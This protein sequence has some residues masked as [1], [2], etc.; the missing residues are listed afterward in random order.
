MDPTASIPA[1]VVV[2]PALDTLTWIK[3]TVQLQ[4]TALNSTGLQL[5]AAISWSSSAPDVAPVS[6]SGLVTAASNGIAS[7]TARAGSASASTTVFVRQVASAFTKESGD[8]QSGT[9]GEPLSASLVVRAEDQGGTPVQGAQLEWSVL[10]GDGALESSDATTGGDG[11]A[12][13]SWRLGLVAGDQTVEARVDGGVNVVF[14]AVS[15]LP[16]ADRL[17]IS[18]ESVTLGLVGDT[19]RFTAEAF[20]GEMVLDGAPMTFVSGDLAVASVDNTG[21]ATAVGEGTATVT[22]QSG[23]ATASATVTVDFSTGPAPTIGSIQPTVL[24]EGETATIT[25]SG[26][27]SSVQ[28]NEVLIDGASATITSASATELQVDV[29]YFDCYPSRSVTVLVRRDGQEDSQAAS[30]TP[31]SVGSLNVGDG[32]YTTDAARCLHLEG[33]GVG[34]E[35]LIGVLSVSEAPSSLTP[36]RLFSRS[37]SVLASAQ[38]PGT[39][40]SP[41]E[42]R[43]IP[44]RFSA[45]AATPQRAATSPVDV[46]PAAADAWREHWRAEAKLR[47][48][49]EE[50]IRSLGGAEALGTLMRESPPRRA[51]GEPQRAVPCVDRDTVT[52]VATFVGSGTIF[53]EDVDNPGPAFL[54]SELQSLDALY[55]DNIAATLS[56]YIGGDQDVDENGRMVVLMTR[57]V[58]EQENLLGYVW[59]GDQITAAYCPGSNEAEIFYGVVPDPDGQVG[60]A[61]TKEDVLDLY[62][63]LIAHEV[64]HIIQ[65]SQRIWS[66]AGAKARWEL[67]GGATFAEQLV[68]NRI[69]GHGSRQDLQYSEWSAGGGWYYD[70]VADLA[71]YFGYQ[72]ST[73]RVSGA[74]EQC[75][76]IGNAS[77]GNDGPCPSSRLVY[78]VPATLLRYV[79]DHWGL[80]FPGGETA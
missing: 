2:T 67:E 53:L 71:A 56:D 51:A 79:L 11:L 41:P 52:A 26:F 9:A 50:M 69:F 10:S 16:E 25:G 58:N 49:E 28:A 32:W 46:V 23:S 57:A 76:W 20:A 6:S 65:F 45:L 62:P 48:Q 17:E 39:A 24:V 64:T 33:G 73:S 42:A 54:E 47:E 12:N 13:A 40:L 34:R 15:I 38:A 14:S 31:A 60:R 44:K 63:S 22:A 59:S 37:G 5:A 36:A 75:T 29:P 43:P 7:I 74:P 30:I 27:G 35:Y 1:T 68:G 4:G 21:L 78:G 77:D 72:S 80:D 55:T 18:P 3:E 61:W 70:W 19:T 8:G 66:G